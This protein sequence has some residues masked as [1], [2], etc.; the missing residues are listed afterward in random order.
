MIPETSGPQP[1]PRLID[2]LKTA[3]VEPIP[4]FLPSPT[5]IA[6]AAGMDIAPRTPRIRNDATKA[7]SITLVML[8][9]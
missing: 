4:N 1:S 6:V 9:R 3:M 5:I 2:T 8:P 7:T